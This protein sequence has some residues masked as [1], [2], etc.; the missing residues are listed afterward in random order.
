M[1]CVVGKGGREFRSTR[2]GGV[3]F[4]LSD[5]LTRAYDEGSKKSVR[6][7]WVV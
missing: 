3:I 7:Q 4:G 5:F 2:D 6:I 1:C